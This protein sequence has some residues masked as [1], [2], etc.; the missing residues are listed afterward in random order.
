MAVI[1]LAENRGLSPEVLADN[2]QR[3]ESFWRHE[4]DYLCDVVWA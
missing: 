2:R 1:T 4:Q 3:S